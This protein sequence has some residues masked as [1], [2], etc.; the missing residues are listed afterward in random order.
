MCV[1]AAMMMAI[2]S[3]G[4]AAASIYSATRAGKGP[5]PA[6]EQAKADAMATQTAN[7]RLAQRRTALRKNSLLT[8]GADTAS[9][10]V[11]GGGKPTLG[12]G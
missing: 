10:G 1:S 2:A 4:S 9:S 5:D 6:K 3:A 7:G 11:L 8:G 12:G